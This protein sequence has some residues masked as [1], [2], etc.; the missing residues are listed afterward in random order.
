MILSI[1]G[2]SR[3]SIEADFSN[4]LAALRDAQS[5]IVQADSLNNAR[6]AKD[7]EDA[8]QMREAY[9]RHMRQIQEMADYYS[10]QWENL[11]L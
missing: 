2:N 4:V 3:A 8:H 6:N 11:G 7:N 5:A 9:Q 10:E 1:N